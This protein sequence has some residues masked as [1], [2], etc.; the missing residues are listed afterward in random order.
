MQQCAELRGAMFVGHPSIIN[1]Q[2]F[3]HVKSEASRHIAASGDVKDS[4]SCSQRYS[5]I[6]NEI[7]RKDISSDESLLQGRNWSRELKIF[8]Q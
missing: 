1:D 3:V 4:S 2:P 6:S 8:T 7:R 5:T